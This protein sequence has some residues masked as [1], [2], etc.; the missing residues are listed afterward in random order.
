[1]SGQLLDFIEETITL[2]AVGVAPGVDG[3]VTIGSLG[4]GFARAK[5]YEVV[6]DSTSANFDVEIYESTSRTQVNRII[7]LIGI[8]RHTNTRF[9]EGA[10]YRDRDI[11]V[12]TPTTR[13]QFYARGINNGGGAVTITIRIKYLLFTSQ[14]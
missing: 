13:A 10:Q 11:S 9:P 1:M 6:A 14:Q 2:A 8:N 3:A 5:I 12:L 7:Q 4:D